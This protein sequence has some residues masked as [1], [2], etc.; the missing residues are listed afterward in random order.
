MV[1]QS[2]RMTLDRRDFLK[3]VAAAGA[4]A[5]VLDPGTAEAAVPYRRTLP[6]GWTYPVA[7]ALLPFGH[8][9]MS[10]DPLPDRVMLWTRI[11]IP[12]ARGWD[13]SRVADPQG[14]REVAVS[15]VIARDVAL[16]DIVRRGTVKTSASRDWTVRADA[17]RLPAATTL[18]YAFTALGY[19]SPIGRTRTAPAANAAVSELTIAHVAC[20]SWWQDVW[21][22]Y[23]RIGERND[24][25]L[26]LHAGDHIYDNSGGHPASRYWMGQRS[27]DK[28]IDN[29]DVA[30]VAE[31]RRRYALYYADPKL[32]AAH[33]AAPWAIMPDQH[34]DDPAKDLTTAQARSIFFEWTATRAVRP[35]GSGQFVASPGPNVNAPVPTGNAAAYL[36]RSLRMG[37]LCEVILIDVRRFAGRPKDTSKV[38]GD[39]QWAW[40]ERTLKASKSATHRVVVNQVNLSQLRAFNLPASQAFADAFGI[41]PNAPQGEI[42]TTAWGGQPQERTKLYQFLRAQGIVD[43]IVLSGDSHGWFCHDLVEDPELPSYEPLTGGGFVGCGGRRGRALRD[44]P[45]RWAGRHRRG[46]VLRG[47]PRQPR[48]CLQ[49]RC[50]LRRDLPHRCSGRDARAR[51]GRHDGQPQPPLLQLARRVRPPPGAPAPGRRNAGAVDLTAAGARHH[52]NAS[53]AVPHPGRRASLEPGPAASRGARNASLRTGPSGSDRCGRRPS[54]DRPAPTDG[55]AAAA[56][57][58]PSR[59]TGGGGGCGLGVGGDVAASAVH[60]LFSDWLRGGARSLTKSSG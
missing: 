23:A 30:S 46:A 32:I 55:Q 56:G 14:I 17:D 31:C 29:R 34:D 39:V 26:V 60:V 22:G 18:Y 21:N 10:G 13:S 52:G 27:W 58:G 7:E 3:A 35:D 25:D 54:T 40:L 1:L 37:S 12:D 49:R 16:T 20:T 38:L 57:D 44:G 8:A 50:R 48:C 45:P 4:A 42:Y 36:Y 59:R 33:L 24:L 51:A 9:V 6:A 11:T 53:P 5:T 15:W 47:G 28:D 41:D 43:N 19:R 2:A